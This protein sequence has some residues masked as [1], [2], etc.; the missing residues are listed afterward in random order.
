VTLGGRRRLPDPVADAL[1]SARGR[2]GLPHRRPWNSS[3]GSH[4]QQPAFLFVSAFPERGAR[5]WR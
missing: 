4:Y 2:E 5:S 3:V 1:Q